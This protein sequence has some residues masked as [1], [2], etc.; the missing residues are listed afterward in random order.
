MSQD[1]LT[2]RQRRYNQVLKNGQIN[3][4]PVILA[5]VVALIITIAVFGIREEV[6]WV[7]QLFSS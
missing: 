3:E 4:G 5:F 1:K 7:R 6:T 2:P